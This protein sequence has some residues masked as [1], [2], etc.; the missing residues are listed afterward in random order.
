MSSDSADA[1][2]NFPN[3]YRQWK[4]HD[5]AYHGPGLG[6]YRPPFYENLKPEDETR[7]WRFIEENYL[8]RYEAFMAVRFDWFSSGLWTIP[9]P[10]SVADTANVRLE[11]LGMP[12]RT[13]ALL[14]EW[15]DELDAQPY[16]GFN[17]D[18]DYEASQAKGL[19][20]AKEVKRFLG[21]EVYLEFRLFREII[22]SDGEAVELDVPPFIQQ[23]SES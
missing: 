23:F 7:V 11:R 4:N 14:G 17:E 19:A 15:H 22:V 9:Y 12:E 5:L 13:K 3:R 6:S 2:F 21:K 8:H 10:G 20:A 1:D 18:F 16:D